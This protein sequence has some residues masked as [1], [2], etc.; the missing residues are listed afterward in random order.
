MMCYTKLSIKRLNS[1]NSRSGNGISLVKTLSSLSLQYRDVFIYDSSYK[2]KDYINN[3]NSLKHPSSSHVIASYAHYIHNNSTYHF[4]SLGEYS[5]NVNPAYIISSS[6]SSSSNSS[7]SS[8]NSSSSSS[9]SSSSNSSISSSSS[10]SNNSSSTHDMILWPD[11][12]HIAGL[13]KEDIPSI[14][15]LIFKDNSISHSSLS[16]LLPASCNIK[17]ITNT[18]IVSSTS[19]IVNCDNANL[20]LKHFQNIINEE[21]G[22]TNDYTYLL[23]PEM[24]GGANVL[25][26]NIND[27][28]ETAIDST[29]ILM[30]GEKG[31]REFWRKFNKNE[32]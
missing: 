30:A 8:S 5:L 26:L 19:N 28:V 4:N 17:P 18:V 16:S 14:M 31:V 10:S 27:K 3:M 25:L 11:R 12:L 23:V 15:K 13:T 9:S 1:S 29:K 6:S 21:K 24:K 2:Y 7:S 20:I 32:S 22:N